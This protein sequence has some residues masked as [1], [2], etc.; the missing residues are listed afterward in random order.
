MSIS[1]SGLGLQT[2]PSVGQFVVVKLLP[3][4]HFLSTPPSVLGLL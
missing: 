1:D 3:N 4:G 2:S